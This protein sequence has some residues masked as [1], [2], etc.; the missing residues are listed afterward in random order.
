MA[1]M[2][3]DGA[4]V[5]LPDL[6]RMLRARGLIRVLDAVDV[7]HEPVDLLQEVDGSGTV[8]ERHV[9]QVAQNEDVLGAERFDAVHACL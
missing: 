7:V 6:R 5:P 3:V 2:E 4:R 1:L 9:E 8:L